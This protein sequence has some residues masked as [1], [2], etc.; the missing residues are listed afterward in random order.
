MSHLLLSHLSKENNCPKLVHDLFT[1]HADGTQ[2]IVASRYNE[3]PV[4]RITGESVIGQPK[5]RGIA[6]AQAIQASLF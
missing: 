2:I 6:I 1:T 4:Y 5:E 3:T